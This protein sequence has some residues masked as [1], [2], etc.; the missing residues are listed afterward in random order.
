MK[1]RLLTGMAG[2][3]RSWS[4]GDEFEC[5]APEAARL[6]EAGAAKA[7]APA[8]ERAVTPAPRVRRGK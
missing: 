4:P 7:I 5:D 1:V 8:I 2:G 6:I 3:D